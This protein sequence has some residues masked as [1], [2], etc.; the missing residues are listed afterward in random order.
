MRRSDQTM[1][2]IVD[3]EEVRRLTTRIFTACGAPPDE[4]AAVAGHLV[5]SNLMGYDTHGVIRVPQYVDDVRNGVIV[6]GARTTL[7]RETGST[8]IVD[9][10][11]NF[12]Q[13]GGLRGIEHAIEKA[14]VQGIAMVVVRRSNHA[15]R[16][17][18]YTQKAAE[19]G[20]PALGFC[21]SPIHG[22]FVLPWGGREGRL[23]TN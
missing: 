22:H 7:H 21:N 19:E 2:V 14:H 20:F 6:P 11:W 15:G 4:A 17:G 1:P 16:L 5:T 10:G 13:I 18:A 3:A 23:A 12:G 9:G 8:A